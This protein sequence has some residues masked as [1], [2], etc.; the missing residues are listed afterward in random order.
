[1]TAPLH[2]HE[3]A[4]TFSLERKTYSDPFARE[5]CR[6]GARRYRYKADGD[7]THTPSRETPWVVKW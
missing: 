3:V 2:V 4:W 1:M 6:C 7:L 5:E